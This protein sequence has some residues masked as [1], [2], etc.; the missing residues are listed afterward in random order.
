[1][2]WGSSADRM[3]QSLRSKSVLVAAFGIS[4]CFAVRSGAVRFIV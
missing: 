2:H 4:V 3:L 1:M